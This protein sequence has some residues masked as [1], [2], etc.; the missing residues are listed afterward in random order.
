MKIYL[1]TFDLK[2]RIV[3]IALMFFVYMANLV[4]SGV[5]IHVLSFVATFLTASIHLDYDTRIRTAPSTNSLNSLKIFRRKLRKLLLNLLAITVYPLENCKVVL[6]SRTVV[7]G[8]CSYI[9]FP[10][11]CMEKAL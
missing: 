8:K 11:H 2:V 9:K 1:R 4:Q 6:L 5:G 7:S 10:K 3:Y